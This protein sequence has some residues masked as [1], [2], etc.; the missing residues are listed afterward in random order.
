MII[1]KLFD[2]ADPKIGYAVLLIHSVLWYSAFVLDCATLT[3]STF[4]CNNNDFLGLNS[5]SII[6]CDNET[7]G[8]MYWS[9]TS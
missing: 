7:Y 3:N 2:R 1:S 8:E 5:G 6:D 4:A 9:F